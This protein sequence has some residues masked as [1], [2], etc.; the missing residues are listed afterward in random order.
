MSGAARASEPSAG[1]A[2][3]TA[4]R[5]AA[6]SADAAAEDFVRRFQAA[7]SEPRAERLGSLLH[8]DVVLVQP[9]MPRRA[10]REQAVRGFGRLLRAIPDLRGEVLDWR[11]DGSL[12]FIELTLSGTVAWRPFEWTLADRITLE[13]GVVRE[14]VSYFDPLPLLLETLKRPS[15]WADLLG[16]MR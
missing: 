7:W 3:A 13:D 10:G 1:A 9:L 6:A 11:G 15:R 8:E 4:E 16:L 2:G 14:R 12:V 5:A